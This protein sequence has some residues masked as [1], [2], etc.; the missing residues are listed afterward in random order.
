MKYNKF[1]LTLL[2]ATF[3]VTA[4]SGELCAAE[5]AGAIF[6]VVNTVQAYRSNGW[7]NCYEGMELYY[8]DQIKT[9]ENSKAMLIF[10]DGTQLKLDSET[11]VNLT[12][13][14][15]EK[16]G[17]IEMIT[18]AIWSKIKPQEDGTSPALEIQSPTSVCAIRG[19]E[20]AMRLDGD[21]QQNLTT[22]LTVISGEVEF[23]NDHGKTLIP[24]SSQSVA[25]VNSAPTAPVVLTK[26]QINQE[27]AWIDFGNPRVMVLV[28]ELNLGEANLVSEMESEINTQL[29]D[30]HYHIIDPSQVD[31]IR[32]TDEAKK[33]ITG[34]E[35]AA[36]T[37]GKRFG[38]D[39]TVSG[40]VETMFISE[41]KTDENLM[42]VCEARCDIKVIVTDTAQLLFSKK[43]K[44]E[45]TSL[46]KEAAGI[47]AM[48]NISAQIA[49]DLV[50]EIPQGYMTTYKGQRA[51]QL[52]ISNCSFTDRDKIIEF[53]KSI[54]DVND[55]VFPRTFENSIAIIDVE[56]NGTSEDLVHEILK[57]ESL[58]IEV[59]GLTMNR[60][61]IQVIK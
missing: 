12:K 1:I 5:K 54:P 38:C 17:I 53:L 56:Y 16:I 49:N 22:T 61:E 4:I 44:A 21:D 42:Y 11:T 8:G 39:V 35:L 36:A 50:W 40:K 20:V 43:L 26:E 41:Q 33:A 55:K 25:M 6:S 37:L 14:E 58:K 52:I 60:I 48:E 30:S 18:G 15:E 13:K 9:L 47:R 45:G 31:T 2:I 10:N 24:A 27:I 32:E 59:T 57:I 51:T 7:I 34:D 28:Q 3:L 19:T 29:T 46:S 23:K